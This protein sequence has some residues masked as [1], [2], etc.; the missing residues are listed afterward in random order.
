MILVTGASGVLG[1]SLVA[2]LQAQGETVS[3][4]SSTDVDLRDREATMVAIGR[5]RP[6]RIFHLAAK[7]HGLGGNS[8]F[9]AEMFS[10]NARINMN[11]ID[12]A[13][14][15]GC[16]K[17]IAVST[18]A[19]YASDLPRPVKETAIWDGAPHASERA[20]GQAKRAMLAQLEAYRS[21]YGFAFAYP[22]MTNL[23][24]PHDR[25]DPVH[26]HVVP[27]LIAKFHAAAMRGGH[28]DVWG[29]GRAERDFL[30]ADDA[31]RALTLVCQ[32]G[33]GPINVA[34]GKTVAVREIVNIL[35][36]LTGVT[37]VRWD[38]TKPDGQLERSY[39]VSKLLA[40]G[41]DPA[42]KIVDGL[43]R[44]YDWYA[45]QFPNVRS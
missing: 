8:A 40:L 5:L 19:I 42:H 10:D 33:E 43:H 12:A 18:V 2:Q 23:Y 32:S 17:F 30:F 15:C 31:A 6:R 34:T 45:A 26:G 28:V 39:D 16:E 24:G 41:F 22:I 25:Y 14:R 44:T 7:V 9:Q 3:T 20:Y 36:E 35:V 29:T 27:S 37:D 1:M 13:H 11:V 4:V 21:Q 38:A